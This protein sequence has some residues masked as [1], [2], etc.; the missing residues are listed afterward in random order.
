MQ[1]TRR[2]SWILPA[3]A[4]VILGALGATVV[5]TNDPV[6]GPRLVQASG[7]DWSEELQALV[8]QVSELR[9]M[10]E[11]GALRTE[12][13]LSRLPVQADPATTAG[14]HER[15]DELER[16]LG[17]MGS[18]TA[19][20]GP[21]NRDRPAQRSEIQS[22]VSTMEIDREG[23]QLSLRLMTVGEAV[24]RFGFPD[25]AEAAQGQ[26]YDMYWCYHDLDAVGERYSPLTLYF[27]N[28]LVLY[29]ETHRPH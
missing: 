17:R 6:P 15:V 28:G 25:Q 14:L 3:L 2:T 23:A 18:A 5:P 13:L 10:L 16:K 22:I 8:G 24:E 20:R 7:S 1:S 19:A 26:A 9:R 11:G 12:P 4:G 29:V 27:V 21:V